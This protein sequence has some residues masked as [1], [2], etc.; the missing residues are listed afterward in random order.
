MTAPAIPALSLHDD[1]ALSLAGSASLGLAPGGDGWS[2]RVDQL[3]LQFPQAYRRYLE[4]L[5]AAWTLD[6]L[7]MTGRLRWSGEWNSGALTSGRVAP[8]G[9]VT[10][11]SSPSTR[12][13][14]QHQQ[15]NDDHRG[16]DTSYSLQHCG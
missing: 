5:A 10:S 6:G 11:E 16:P 3:E 4:P 7:E 2:V 13:Q 12:R 8:F 14:W 9:K 1:T 15:H